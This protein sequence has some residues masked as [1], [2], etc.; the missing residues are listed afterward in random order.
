[1]A[2][3]SGLLSLDRLFVGVVTLM[4]MAVLV[5]GLWDWRSADPLKAS[6]FLL[7]ALVAS[8]LKVNL[9]QIVGT[10]S[11]SFVFILLGIV[12]LSLSET[13][14]MGAAATA[15]QVRAHRSL[16]RVP[17]PTLFHVANN[18]L[19]VAIAHRVY[20]SP[21]I[22][23]EGSMVAMVLAA[24]VLFAMN[25]LPA[26]IV[27][28]IG[29]G[30]NLAWVWRECNFRVFPYYVVG[31]VLASL[32]HFSTRY[33]GG[34]SPFL[35]LPVA[36]LI[37]WSYHSYMGRLSVQKASLEEMAALHQRTIEALALAIEA[38]DMTAHD[39]LRRL[40]M[41]C[42]EIGRRLEM[43]AEDLEALR[44]AAILHDIGKLAVPEHI[45]SKPGKLTREEFEKIKIHPV[46]GAEILERV[47]FPYPVAKIV[48]F[49]H[50]KWNGGGYPSGLKGDAIP[51]GARI[52]AAVDCLD[53][54]ITERPYRRAMTID[55]ALGRI[56]A[57]AGV[58][59]DPRVV[60]AIQELSPK[61]EQRLETQA[62]N[63]PVVPDPLAASLFPDVPADTVRMIADTTEVSNKP[64]FLDT[65]AAARQE[66]QVL[67]ELT[68]DLGKSLHL[69]ET[70]SALSSG[71]RRLVPFET[72]VIYIVRDGNL[73]PRYASGECTSLFLSRNIPIGKG[74]AGWT[75]QNRKPILNGN[76]A[77]EMGATS[78][79]MKGLMLNSALVAPLPGKQ[80]TPGVLML[81]RR[82]FEAFDKDA[83]RI[84]LAV[85]SKLG[86]VVENAH[87]YEQ[88]AASASTDFL[89]GLPNARALQSQLEIELSRSRRL[90]TALTVLVTDLDG[91]KEVNDRFG[92]LEGNAV[93]QAVA[94]ALRE[95]CREYDYVARMGGDE[96]VILLP[97]LAEAD[98]LIKVAQLNRA[99]IDAGKA[100]VPESKLSL[101]VG[102]A[103]FPGDG[104]EPERLLA[105]ADQRMYQAKTLRKLKNSRTGPRGYDFDWLE[106]TSTQP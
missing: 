4:G 63:M 46:V 89:T 101:S 27:L 29:N 28:A 48:R 45:L 21:L 7:L 47:N 1:M 2:P 91:F 53:A 98:V 77:V 93:L 106:T 75:A 55:E 81:C 17:A 41:Y 65:I 97:G 79:A 78:E 13:L 18:S 24:T 61:L 100:V 39:H 104:D 52:L 10:M 44:A 59:F 36:F 30:R 94:K 9:P 99:V 19:A 57:E 64:A 25:T 49:H 72:M 60:H 95:C 85:C 102:Q 32:F 8:G 50:E 56:Q 74:I 86:N 6:F 67:L 51:V 16:L 68:E 26:A 92:H 40:Q 3:K 73:V 83:L 71:L 43:N 35:L 5:S 37:Y 80:A 90:G 70:L 69:E 11:F 54:L 82:N 14:L 105:E 103:R 23:G 87:K 15:V 20:Y 42:V 33:L 62:D 84:L 76:P 12:E 96:F 58:S 34:Q 38:K 88:A 31:A 66:A 22:G